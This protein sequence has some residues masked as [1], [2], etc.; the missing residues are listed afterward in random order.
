MVLNILYCDI[1]NDNFDY[2]V[3]TLFYIKSGILR[4]RGDKVDF[5]VTIDAGRVF[6]AVIVF[7]LM[8]VV[9]GKTTN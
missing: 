1:F 7:F 4:K 6:I 5:V 3:C 9:I 2:V 8:G